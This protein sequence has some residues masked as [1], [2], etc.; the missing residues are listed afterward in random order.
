MKIN[1]PKVSIIMSCYNAE[2]YVE[3]AINSIIKQ[4]YRNWEL[5][6]IDDRSSDSTL[7]I[8]K[9]YKS[10]KIKILALNKNIGQHKAINLALKKTS[11]EYIAILDSD[12]CAHRKRILEQVSELKKNT[13]IGLVVSRYKIIDEK[14]RF[15]KNSE[16]VSEKEFARRFPCE[17]LC[18]FSASMFRKKFVKR[19][20]FYDKN[21]DY[22]NDYYFFLKIFSISKIKYVNK[23]HTFYR[24]HSNS[25]TNTF[26]KKNLIFENLKCLE[27]SRKKGFIN[28]SNIL[29]Y[30]KIV[31]K[32]YIKLL[33]AVV[34]KLVDRHA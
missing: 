28:K 5:F 29:L 23:F 2:R 18:C 19:L 33:I 25:R 30:I 3:Y 14:N 15:K 10:K 16:F 21:Y 27:W 20:G 22:C 8:L 13:S 9:K 32:N 6:L 11:G 7:K 34:L 24:I 1:Q 17:N 26:S 12:D 31:L 4:E